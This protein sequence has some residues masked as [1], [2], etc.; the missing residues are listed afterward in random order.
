ML[1]GLKDLENTEKSP[2]EVIAS[3][4]L[5]EA[6]ALINLYEYYVVHSKNDESNFFHRIK[7]FFEQI[8]C[9][10]CK[11]HGLAEEEVYG[12]REKSHWNTLLESI[13]EDANPDTPTV[14]D[15]PNLFYSTPEADHEGW[16]PVLDK[17]FS[18]YEA[19]LKQL[20]D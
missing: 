5:E 3:F 9:L 14:G 15:I 12:L 17:C 18:Y 16:K 6:K 10:L 13:Q 2:E 7:G 8:L 20:E 1:E 11:K 4:S 19:S